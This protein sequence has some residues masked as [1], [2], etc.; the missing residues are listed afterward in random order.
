MPMKGLQQEKIIYNEGINSQE[1]RLKNNDK[2][3]LCSL[4][5]VF[6]KATN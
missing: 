6:Y 4:V 2:T 5:I 1:L 3:A